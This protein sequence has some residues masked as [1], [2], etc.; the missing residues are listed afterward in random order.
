MKNWLRLTLASFI[1]LNAISYAD[2][3]NLELSQVREYSYYNNGKLA[4]ERIYDK[5]E[6]LMETIYY[7]YDKYGILTTEEISGKNRN[8]LFAYEY[9][10]GNLVKI[11]EAKKVWNYSNRTMKYEAVGDFRT[12]YEYNRYGNLVYKYEY[13]ENP[14]DKVLYGRSV[15]VLYKARY[16][17]DSSGKITL[18]TL[19]EDGIQ[20][21]KAKCGYD[22]DGKLIEE[23]INSVRDGDGF[24]F[25][26]KYEYDGNLLYSINPLIE[27]AILK[28]KVKYEYNP[29]RQ[30][31]RK[32]KF[33]Y[34]LISMCRPL[35]I[36]I[37]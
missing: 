20:I 18:V 17:Y 8:K 31:M 4:I 2:I 6:I 7:Y 12:E 13:T 32:Y 33:G 27:D 26:N 28:G 23:E 37:K 21:A 15:P 5:D 3:A 24:V 25:G 35:D 9:K 36:F 34:Y 16:E 11:Y 22:S 30:L 29:A 14:V 19:F 10:N 1:C